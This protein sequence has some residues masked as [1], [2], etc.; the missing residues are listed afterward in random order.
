MSIQLW[1]SIL[2][3]IS[4]NLWRSI[5]WSVVH[6]TYMIYEQNYMERWNNM[7]VKHT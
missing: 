5:R 7:H 3:P 4:I 6:L 1:R 2:P